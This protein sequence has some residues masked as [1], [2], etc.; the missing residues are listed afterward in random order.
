MKQIFAD[1]LYWVALV[2]PKDRWHEK[3]R[4]VAATLAS[5]NLVTTE[6]VLMEFLNFFSSY[7]P[8]MKKAIADNLQDII[9]A[10]D[11]EVV[12]PSDDLLLSGLKF[13]EKRLDKG[14]SMVDC[15]SMVVM[16]D[17]NLTEVL[18]HDQ[19]FTQEGFTILL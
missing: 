16:R 9:D 12:F 14:Y 10:P 6:A 18:T 13:Y 17:R 11:I 15:I 3:S 19:H 2:N 5:T 4:E 8:S 7:R 1:S